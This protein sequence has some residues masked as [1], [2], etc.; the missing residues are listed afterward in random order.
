MPLP[1]LSVLPTA[2]ART[3]APATFITRADAFIA[4]LPTLQTEINTFS[5]AVQSAAA[6][7]VSA[8]FGDAG[9][10]AMAGNTPAADRFIY[11]TSGSAS[12]LGIITAAGRAL[13][14]DANAAA[15]L[16]TLGVSAFMQ[17]VLDDTSA[18]TALGTLGAAPLASP[19]FTGTPA[20]P[21]ASFGT[22]TTQLATTAFV[23][24]LRDLP[25]STKTGAYT[26]ALADRGT[27][28]SITTG[29]IVIPANASVAFPIGS[30]IVIYND[31]A[32]TQSITITTDTLRQAGTAN[33]GARTLA[34]YGV[35]TLVKVKS[36]TWVVTGS[37][38]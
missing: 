12:T 6:V 35:A 13:L 38:T 34:Q 27:H 28:I 17:T 2:P 23:D 29:G 9:L 26:L 33:T 15:Q 20:A 31:S 22:A 32:S 4:A 14:D 36:T 7:V 24:T 8:T 10:V 30:T 21:T 25:Q 1:T 18:A 16:T 19:T 11:F 5:A 37:V 3:D